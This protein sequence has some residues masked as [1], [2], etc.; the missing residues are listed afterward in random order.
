MTKESK[1]RREFLKKGA[2]A[3][4]LLIMPGAFNSFAS[5]SNSG[6]KKNISRSLLDDLQLGILDV[7]K[8]PY[9]ADPTGV[10]DS[11]AA[12]QQAVNDSCSERLICFF[13]SGTYLISD[14]ISCEIPVY[15]L[16]VGNVT[17]SEEDE[18]GRY[19]LVQ[20]T[21]TGDPT[22]HHYWNNS[23]DRIILL[24]ST[25][26]SR[27]V[28]KL[29]AGAEGF[30]NPGNPKLAVR[31]WAQ[32]R[33]DRGGA[34]D[35]N[36]P[37]LH[38]QPNWGQEQPNISF[39]NV[40]KGIDIDLSGNPGAIGLRHTGSQG[41]YMMDSYINASG[42]FAGLSNCCGQ[43]AGTYNIV[44]QGG[45][46]GIRLDKDC[47][48]PILASCKFQGQ[49]VACVHVTNQAGFLP[50]VMVGC[51][52]E[53]T[54]DAAIDLS[55]AHNGYPGLNLIDCVVKVN[56]NGVIAKTKASG[57]TL[58]FENVIV[59]GASKVAA[60][61]TQ[62]IN[63]AAWT[64]V[65]EYSNCKGTDRNLVNGV[66][67]NLTFFEHAESSEPD[68]ESLHAKHWP[69]LASFE[70]EDAVNVKDFGA[71]GNN[72]ADDTEAFKQALAASNKVFVPKGTY[73][74]NETLSIGANTHLFGLPKAYTSVSSSLITV[75]D[76]DATP[77]LGFITISGGTTWRAG[78]G[79]FVFAG[80]N[81]TFAGNGG[82]RF[83]GLMGRKII[84]NNSRPVSIYAYNVERVTQNPMTL[85]RNAKD[86][87]IYYVK[88][89]AG[90]R[91]DGADYNTPIG[92]INSENI[93]IYCVSGPVKTNQGKPMVDI[94]NSMNV[95][96]S[97]IKSVTSIS[98]AFPTV[99]ET[100]GAFTAEVP[101][102]ARVA[103]YLRNQP[104]G[105]SQ[106]PPVQSSAFPNPFVDKFKIDIPD[107]VK[108]MHIY[109]VNGKKIINRVVSM[110]KEY[111]ITD[112]DN[113]PAGIYFISL[114]GSQNFNIKLIKSM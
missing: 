88:V 43:G 51:L 5:N 12:I 28:L 95:I 48:Y 8:A 32:T 2:M 25:K 98:V 14:T 31:I 49:T 82:G 80:G 37:C 67:S 54:G 69:A 109:D 100:I 36:N 18:C 97:Q 1:S 65:N 4:S 108:S 104:T 40:F 41:C 23:N 13:P 26:G 38:A 72:Q 22:K 30:Q 92:I 47:R 77:S 21:A 99:K 110:S 68:Y 70:D 91:G 71:I 50:M 86:V 24:G 61:D 102:T 62:T 73:K 29:K 63:P 3:S 103:L 45:Q 53:T 15:K 81:F 35:P 93:G 106:N 42:A 75:D 9:N 57:E 19:M 59:N 79:D 84:E 85:I 94:V 10:N 39:N 114:L 87:K 96:V 76:P 66:S 52:L 7:T 20:T 74:L 107:G 112:L 33:M 56:G 90:T 44:V 78:R 55:I 113:K 58:Y 64:T 46:Y 89:E 83:Y 11:T 17:G 6:S 101:H 27:P 105:I 16:P 60:N 34:V 111:E